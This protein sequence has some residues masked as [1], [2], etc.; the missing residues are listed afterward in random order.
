MKIV[1]IFCVVGEHGE[2]DV[3]LSK[4]RSKEGVT[5]GDSGISLERS[6]R[7]EDIFLALC[8]A[9]CFLYDTYESFGEA[10]FKVC[11]FF[12]VVFLFEE[13]SFGSGIDK[14]LKEN[15][16]HF[17]KDLRVIV[18]SGRSDGGELFLICLIIFI[19][20][21]GYLEEVRNN[22][23]SVLA[24]DKRSSGE[25]LGD[26]EHKWEKFIFCKHLA[27]KYFLEIFFKR[28]IEFILTFTEKIVD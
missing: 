16:V 21:V 19:I 3:E 18:K 7:I 28:D 22:E 1:Q 13:K 17:C 2:E 10:R 12:L 26:K 25:V 14:S 23:K 15:A 4:S 20:I 27:R 24:R 9:F 5:I 8:V 11:T 6:T